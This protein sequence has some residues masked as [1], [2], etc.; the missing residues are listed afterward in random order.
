MME[1][2]E[3]KMHYLLAEASELAKAAEALGGGAGWI[4][5][6]L[7]GLVLLWLFKFHLPS[8][9]AQIEKLLTMAAADRAADRDSRHESN[10]L[11]Q[12]AISEIETQHRDDAKLDRESFISRQ[13]RTEDRLEAAIR[14]QTAELKGSLQSS[15]RYAMVMTQE[16]K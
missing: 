7:L 8:K 4:G 6:G 9:D 3:T 15:C 14:V 10:M 1:G 13:N 16:K 12:K 2:M 5:A 11:F